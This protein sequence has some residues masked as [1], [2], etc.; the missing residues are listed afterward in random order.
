MKEI[1]RFILA[2]VVLVMLILSLPLWLP[3]IQALA[4]P[5]ADEASNPIKGPAFYILDAGWTTGN[6]TQR[7]LAVPQVLA[8]SPGDEESTWSAETGFLYGGIHDQASGRIYITEQRNSSYESLLNITFAG[9]DLFS[10]N[11][12]W[13]LYL[14]AMDSESGEIVSRVA[15][16]VPAR[17]GSASGLHPIGANATTLFLM[18]YAAGKNLF[19]FDLAA[20]RMS[21]QSWSLCEHGYAMSIQFIPAPARVAALCGGHSAGT[22]SSVTLTRLETNEKK[23]LDLPALGKEEFQSGNGIFLANDWLYVID[24]DAGWL[25]QI[26]L[27]TMEIVQTSNYGDGLANEQ[28]NWLDEFLGWL[29]DQIV[30]PAAA[31]RWAALTAVS[32]DGEWLVVD[33][34][35]SVS[36]GANIDLLLVDLHTLMAVRRFELPRSPEQIAFGSDGSLLVLFGKPSAARPTPAV[37]LDITTAKT[38]DVSAPTHGWTRSVLPGD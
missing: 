13:S 35:F 16:D 34:G 2:A 23:S 22:Q 8:W 15:L 14:T 18:N 31:K 21:E 3:G 33:S 5:R 12:D 37:L 20:Q 4:A 26:E 30:R 25:V 24:S 29:G 17:D 38:Q 10:P 32:P 6:L 7:V 36:Q 9:D 19:A 28:S 11:N 1:P 27:A